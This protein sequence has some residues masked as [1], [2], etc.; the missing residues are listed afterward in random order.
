MLV[1]LCRHVAGFGEG[2]ALRLRRLQFAGFVVG[3]AVLITGAWSLGNLG[4]TQAQV[5][6]GLLLVC[7]L[8]LAVV[9][10]GMM[11]TLVQSLKG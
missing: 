7:S 11:T 1:M 4:L 3:V 6:L 10:F 9:V 5:T 2:V 8:S